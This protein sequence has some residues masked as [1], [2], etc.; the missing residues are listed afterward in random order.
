MRKNKKVYIDEY[1]SIYPITLVV[2]NEAAKAKDLNKKYKW[3]DGL[4]IL[5]SEIND[6][7]GCVI[8]CSKRSDN[9]KVLIVKINEIN[10]KLDLYATAVHEAGHVVLTTYDHIGDNICANGGKQEPFCY[11]L[12]WVTICIYKTISKK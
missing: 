8:K 10:N 1:E 5:D 3:P 12:E 9:T 2:A 4:D 6:C 7:N 11:Y